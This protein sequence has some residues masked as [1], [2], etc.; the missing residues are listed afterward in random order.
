MVQRQDKSFVEDRMA[1][2]TDKILNP[3]KTNIL[4]TFST[5]GKTAI[6]RHIS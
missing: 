5:I 4:K 3:I 6:A 1:S 2:E